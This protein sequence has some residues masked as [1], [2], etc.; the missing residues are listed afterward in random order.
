MSTVKGLGRRRDR[1]K[2]L[3]KKHTGYSGIKFWV[4]GGGLRNLDSGSDWGD[5]GSQ[6][7]RPGP[8]GLLGEV[9]TNSCCPGAAGQLPC[10]TLLGVQCLVG[11]EQRTKASLGPALSGSVEGHSF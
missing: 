1:T 2:G 7:A 5:P 9:V 4:M 3:I 6:C 8:D 10:L 11:S